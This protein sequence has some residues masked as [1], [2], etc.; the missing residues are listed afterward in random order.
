MS[1]ATAY[2]HHYQTDENRPF[3]PAAMRYGRH[4]RCQRWPSGLMNASPAI[5]R[6]DFLAR[7]VILNP[8]AFV[9]GTAFAI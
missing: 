8:H 9:A 7:P 6:Q 5:S 4:R 3:S 1:Q 2:Y